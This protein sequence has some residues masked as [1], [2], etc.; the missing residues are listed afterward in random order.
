MEHSVHEVK[1]KN[2]AAG[3]FIDVPSASVTAFDLIFRAG[4][5][6]SPQGKMD[7]AHVMEHL[8][9]GANKLYPSSKEFSKEFTK[10]GAYN[11]AYTGDYHMGYEAECE[12]SETERI[13]DLLCVAIESPLFTE[14]DFKAELGN[15][16]EELKMRRNNDEAELS[17]KLE[18]AMGFVPKSYADRIRE[19]SSVTLKDVENHYKKTHK[20]SNLR[21][22]IAGPIQPIMTKLKKRLE[23]L[24]LAPG[25]GLISLPKETPSPLEDIL[26]VR[27]SDLD[28]ICYRYEIVLPLFKK[29][30]QR[31]SLNSLFDVLFNGFHSRVF[32][33][34]REKGLAYGIYGGQYDTGFNSIATVSGQVQPDNFIEL[35][36]ILNREIKDIATYGVTA[37]ELAEL[38]RRAYGEVQR[39]HQTANQ[40]S[41]W[42]RHSYTMREEIV[43]FHGFKDRLNNI[44]VESIKNIAQD[45]LASQ[46]RGMA[47]M[48]NPAQK[49]DIAAAK[50]SFLA[51]VE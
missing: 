5:Y 16:R 41:S 51:I 47:V 8:V 43:D 10:Y 34:L 3:L 14:K 15:V 25:K 39:H 27:N 40:I 38:K 26:Q 46:V 13:L 30:V 22:V 37:D 29:F 50:Q 23:R 35:L 21:F 9:L 20:S 48:Y 1:L 11:N 2:G 19:L 49:P 6:L 32:G 28:N 12:A 18:Q 7:T 24:D 17:L 36:N 42:Y 4:D 33:E 44:T 31:D 45:V